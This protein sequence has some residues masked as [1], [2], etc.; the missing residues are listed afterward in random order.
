MGAWQWWPQQHSASPWLPSAQDRQQLGQP[1]DPGATFKSFQWEKK[2]DRWVNE[3]SLWSENMSNCKIELAMPF[4]SNLINLVLRKSCHVKEVLNP[5]CRSRLCSQSFVFCLSFSLFVCLFL[6]H[7]INRT[8]D[9][10]PRCKG[11][12]IAHLLYPK[13]APSINIISYVA[14]HTLHY[15]FI[16]LLQR[17]FKYNTLGQHQ[18]IMFWN[19]RNN[20]IFALPTPTP[21]WICF[22]HPASSTILWWLLWLNCEIWWSWIMIVMNYDYHIYDSYDFILGYLLSSIRLSN[23]M[24]CDLSQTKVIRILQSANKRHYMIIM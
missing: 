9:K 21:R 22:L 23:W 14:Y 8:P 16:R 12:K 5:G 20:F 10:S 18:K 11:E 17:E 19:Y 24:P 1:R 6:C 7:L 4:F 15:D 13:I 3:P 2:P